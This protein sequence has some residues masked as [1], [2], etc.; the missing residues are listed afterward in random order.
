MDKRRMCPNCRAFITTDDKV[1]PYCDVPVGPKAIDLRAPT[2]GGFFLT[3]LILTLNVGLFLVTVVASM[4]AG[5]GSAL[6][7][8]DGRTLVLFG[9]KVKEFI[10]A[11]QWWR[12]ITAGYLHGGLMHI[13]MNS[14]AL[15]DLGRQVEMY[16][17]V[18]RMIVIFT[19]ST[20]GGF[21]FSTVWT[22]AL[23]IGASAGIFGLLGAMLAMTMRHEG[24]AARYMR[25]A[26]TRFAIWGLAIGL[27]P[28]LRIDN[29]AHI[30]GI[31]T[32]FLIGYIA[33]TPGGKADPRERIW[34]ALAWICGTVTLYAFVRW[35]L[36]FSTVSPT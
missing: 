28:G 7:G 11:G 18:R 2:F 12:V 16:Y 23:S 20:I 32:G 21:Y 13:F 29:A 4:K 35:F 5:N 30:G 19:L 33:H 26:Y 25:G 14:F 22:P 15:L 27:F 1:C 3:P 31:A 9:G 10:Y 36:W 24:P 8:V 34:N 17:G 6:M